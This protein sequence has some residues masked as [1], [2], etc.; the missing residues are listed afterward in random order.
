MDTI[1]KM[2]TILACEYEQKKWEKGD[3]NF[4]SL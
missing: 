3:Y 4:Y 2:N 1:E